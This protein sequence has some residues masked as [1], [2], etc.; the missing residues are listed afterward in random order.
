MSKIDNFVRSLARFA[1]CLA[2]IAAGCWLCVFIV[3]PSW[4]ALGWVGFMCA[5]LF[6]NVPGAFWGRDR[7]V[8]NEKGDQA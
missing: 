6:V 2:G 7:S 4:S 1:M 5:C 8:I 3:Q